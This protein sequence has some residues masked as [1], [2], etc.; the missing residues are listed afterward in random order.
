MKIKTEIIAA[1]VS[2]PILLYGGY[3][4]EN[5]PL[6]GSNDTQ[7][8]E[9][10]KEINP[11]IVHAKKMIYGDS[12]YIVT[13]RIDSVY[14]WLSPRLQKLKKDKDIRTSKRTGYKQF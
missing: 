1:V 4:F 10:E 5:H 9:T 3:Y 8:D 2:L 7:N 12:M 11:R 14:T 13:Y 6:F